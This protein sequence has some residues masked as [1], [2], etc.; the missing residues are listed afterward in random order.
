MQFLAVIV[1]AFAAFA[2]G[3]VWYGVFSKQ[4]VAASGVPTDS[5]GRPANT[6]VGMTYGLAFVCILV[7]SGMMRHA[8]AASGVDTLGEGVI[9]GLGIGAF[10]IAPWNALNVLFGMRN[11]ALIWIDGGYAAVGCAVAGAI[12][13]LF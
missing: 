10:F 11:K 3:A 4:W 13:V 9:A 7:V 6:G 1:A 12:L 8:L 5:S 2:V